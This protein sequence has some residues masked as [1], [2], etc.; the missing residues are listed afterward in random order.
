MNQTKKTNVRDMVIGAMLIATG[1]LIPMIMPKIVLEPASF[2]LASHAPIMI[3]MFFS[4]LMTAMVAMGTTLGFMIS[5][6]VPTIWMRAAMHIIAMTLG[7]IYLKKHPEII[8][9]KVK[10]QIF[11]IILGIIHAAL[12]VIVV[13]AFYA[14]GMANMNSGAL[15][16]LLLLIGIGG[17]VHSCI[18]FNIALIIGNMMS[19]IFS[20]QIFDRAKSILGNKKSNI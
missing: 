11:N 3:A 4:P 10:L 16:N 13:W 15:Y 5:V 12:E 14:L 1:I 17:I 8:H 20:I 6:P 19:R 9:Q 2:T 18:D 7:A